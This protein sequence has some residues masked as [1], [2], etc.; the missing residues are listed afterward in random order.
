[1]TKLKNKK[2]LQFVSFFL[3]CATLLFSASATSRQGSIDNNNQRI[4]DLKKQ[5]EQIAANNKVTEAR[6]N[7]LRGNINRQEEFI[8]EVNKQIKQIEAQIAAYIELVDAKQQ[9][10]EENQAAIELKEFEILNTENRIAQ[11]EKDIEILDMQNKDNI[12]RFGQT[13]AQMYMNSG[14]DAI[15]L[16]T[17]STSFYDILVRAEMIRNIG[18]KNV[19]FMEKLMLAIEQQEDMI[20]A[21]SSEKAEL[22]IEKEQL[23]IQHQI[24]EAEKKE[25]QTLQTEVEAEVN[26]QYNNLMKLTAE[27]EELQGSVVKLRTAA[28][29][30]EAQIGSIVNQVAQLEADNR[31][32]EAAILAEARGEPVPVYTDKFVLPVDSKFWKIT[33]T[34]GCKCYTPPRKTAHSG[35]DVAA[36]GINGSNIYAVR[37]GVVRQAESNGGYGRMVRIDHGGGIQ[38]LYAHMSS[39]SVKAGQEVK[40]GDVIGKVGNTGHSTGPHL[41]FEVRLNSKTVNPMQ[42][43]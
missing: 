18:E 34:F 41:H 25:L 3:I 30:G 22:E 10:I 4:E 14:N 6:I 15:S 38:T 29:V 31:R 33:C 2:I 13:A 7:D 5:A 35:I 28:R 40:Q 8:R 26:R 1:M 12:E 42:Y 32:I 37:S 27:R 39:I 24:L 20:D 16:L 36:S 11:K 21:L 9:L 23:N 43:F 19:E 17:G